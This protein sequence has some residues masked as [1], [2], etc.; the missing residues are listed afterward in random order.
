MKIQVQT[1]L[2]SIKLRPIDFDNIMWELLDQSAKIL[3]E[4]VGMKLPS[5]TGQAV[6]TLLPAARLLKMAKINFGI[7]TNG[8]HATGR[9]NVQTGAN[10]GDAER[11]KVGGT[12]FF[13]FSNTID[14]M[15]YN[16][17]TDQ[18]TRSGF[19]RKRAWKI[20]EEVKPIVEAKIG[21]L[22]TLKF[23]SVFS[24]IIVR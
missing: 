22:V 5:W 1:Q 20:L 7:F 16:E 11:I 13:S 4:E 24:R 18:A 14:Y 3:I 6:G 17:Y 23:K 2:K 8:S 9:K 19:Q 15:I 21:E 10:K 12:Y